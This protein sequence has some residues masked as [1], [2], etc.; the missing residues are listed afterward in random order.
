MSAI[1]PQ[2]ALTNRR[3]LRALATQ[4]VADRSALRLTKDEWL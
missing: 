4:L 2:Q 3:W 1:E